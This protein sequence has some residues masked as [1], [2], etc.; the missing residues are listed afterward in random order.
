MGGGGV[1]DYIFVR[2]AV[3]QFLGGPTKYRALEDLGELS[4]AIIFSKSIS[5]LTIC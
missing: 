2:I 1:L 4:R 5:T 3:H